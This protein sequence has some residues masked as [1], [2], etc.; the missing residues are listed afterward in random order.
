LA[1]NLGRAK[2]IVKGKRQGAI[3]LDRTNGFFS[4]SKQDFAL[5][6]K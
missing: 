4:Y 6:Y 1:Q 3:G 2:K 5:L